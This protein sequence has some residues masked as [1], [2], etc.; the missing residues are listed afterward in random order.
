MSELRDDGRHDF[1]FLVGDW[2]V[3]HRR[4][5]ARLAGSRDWDEF[6]GTCTLRTILG[7]TGNLDDNVI[8]A[9]QGTYRA[10]TLRLFDP[11]TRLWSI[12]WFDARYPGPPGTPLQGRFENG[13]GRFF[14]DYVQDGKPVRSR[15]QW[16]VL[17]P[18]RAHWEQ[19]LSVDGEASWETNW[20]MDFTRAGR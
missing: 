4:L 2:T 12:W 3:Q 15:F 5:R 13:V 20:A 16:T 17:S 9:P 1:D 11:K 14:E 10:A 18:D 6:A 19:A 8:A 7:G